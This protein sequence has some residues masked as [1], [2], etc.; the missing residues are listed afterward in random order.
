MSRG[1]APTA[2]ESDRIS[3]SKSGPCMACLSFYRQGKLAADEVV[4]GCDYHH[5]KSG[6]IRRGHA[7]GF[8]LCLWH[9]HGSQQLHALGMS[10]RDARARWGPSLL[11][12][13]KRFRSEYGSDDDLIDLQTRVNGGESWEG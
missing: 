5:T 1:K 3:R 2:E 10:S 9:H 8:A 12:E 13:G 4:V 11:D 7:Y 6:N